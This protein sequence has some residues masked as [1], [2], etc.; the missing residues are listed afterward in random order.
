MK[1]P[2]SW[3]KV[4]QDT[5]E[6][7]RGRGRLHFVPLWRPSALLER[8]CRFRFLRT[9]AV[10]TFPVLLWG[11]YHKRK[12]TACKDSYWCR[13]WNAC[14]MK[15]SIK[16]QTDQICPHI[17][18][19]FAELLWQGSGDSLEFSPVWSTRPPQSKLKL[20][21]IYWMDRLDILYRHSR[22]SV[23]ECPRHFSDEAKWKTLHFCLLVKIDGSKV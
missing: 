14:K 18:K 4:T 21:S 7:K 11:A 16:K 15:E 19:P 3:F 23:T 22:S 13:I 1:C 12:V 5:N 9:A 8:S 10:G 20:A 2:G 6:W 17:W